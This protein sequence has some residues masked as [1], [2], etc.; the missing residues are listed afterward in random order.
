MKKSQVSTTQRKV[1]NT[2]GSFSVLITPRTSPVITILVASDHQRLV[3]VST[4]L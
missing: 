3:S 4:I 1:Q 2:P